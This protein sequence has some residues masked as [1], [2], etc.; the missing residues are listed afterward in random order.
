MFVSREAIQNHVNILL[1]F[2]QSNYLMQEIYKLAGMM[3]RHLAVYFAV[4]HIESRVKRQGAVAIIF[5][6]VALGSAGDSGR[7]WLS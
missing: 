4:A 3:R 7:T 6:A 1:G 2:A 5:E